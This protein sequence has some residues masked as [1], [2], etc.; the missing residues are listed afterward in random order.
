MANAYRVVLAAE[1]P[2]LTRPSN[3]PAVSVAAS[4]ATATEAGPSSGA[5]TFSRTGDTS[6]P[7]TVHYAVCWN[8]DTGQ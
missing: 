3:L 8:G 2:V 5:F 6:Q 7:L 1:L 4:T